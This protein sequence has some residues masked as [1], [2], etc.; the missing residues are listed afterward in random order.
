MHCASPAAGSIRSV[1]DLTIEAK[2]WKRGT[3]GGGLLPILQLQLP[4]PAAGEAVL[5]SA[6]V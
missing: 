6:E 1:T 4:S 3:R 2:Q 5:I